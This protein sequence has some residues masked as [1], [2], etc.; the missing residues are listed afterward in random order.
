MTK[1]KD[2]LAGIARSR[3]GWLLMSILSFPLLAY[4]QDEPLPDKFQIEVG[5]FFV[6]RASTTISLARTS[7][8]VAA[9]TIINFEENLGLSSRENVPRIDGY[10]RFGKRSRVDFSYFNI[11]RSGTVTTGD[12]PIDFG[13]ITIPPN[14]PLVS[15]FFN[16][17]VLKA[18]YGFSFYNVPKA[19]F[20]L[21]AGLF[22]ANL[23]VGM[24]APTVNLSDSAK[25][26]AP[27]PVVGAYL[28]Y[29]ISRRW[30]FTAKGDFFYL[31][32]GDYQGNLTDLRVNVEHQTFKNVG[33]GF[34]FNGIE[35]SLKATDGDL[36]GSF[37][38]VI[39]GVQAYVFGAFGAAKYQR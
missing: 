31:V 20:G 22:I 4:A 33:F 30:R 1:K 28:R 32:V 21:S 17:E 36:T 6:T 14:T 10:Y 9:G 11:K 27:L 25:G 34:G 13:D 12:D 16:E 24:S 26:T 37:D 39:S 29:N 38:N 18:T 15:S 5:E 23:G 35:T 3:W 8:V 2:T 19:E 7:G